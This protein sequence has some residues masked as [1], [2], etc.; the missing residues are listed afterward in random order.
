MKR[1]IKSLGWFIR[2]SPQVSKAATFYP[3]K[4]GLPVIRQGDAETVDF[5]WA[6]E[7]IVIECIYVKGKASAQDTNPQTAALVPFF[8]TLDL[9]SVLARYRASGLEVFGPEQRGAARRGSASYSTV[10]GSSW[11]CAKALL[12]P[13]RPRG[14]AP[15]SPGR[16]VQSWLRTDA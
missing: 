6:G 14:C 5:F 1:N 2:F 11:A 4:L 3:Q 10:M 13:L 12:T 8:R 15:G 9:D 7:A 16:G